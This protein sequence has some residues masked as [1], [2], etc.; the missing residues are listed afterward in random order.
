MKSIREIHPSPFHAI[1]E[2]A[3]EKAAADVGAALPNYTRDRAVLEFARLVAL[4]GDGHTTMGYFGFSGSGPLFRAFPIRL[5]SFKDGWFVR[6]AS[7]EYA[8][9]LGG[10]V[11]RSQV[12][13][14]SAC[15]PP[16]RPTSR[17]TMR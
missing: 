5:Y 15:T 13:I 12:S 2:Q 8:S 11:C 1:S 14:P 16:F 7:P 3:F 10:R 6:S 4:I 9:I 17:A